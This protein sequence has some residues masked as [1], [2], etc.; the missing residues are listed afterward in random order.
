MGHATLWSHQTVLAAEPTSVS[1][2]RGFVE[3][4]LLEHDLLF[5]LEDIRL[6]ASELATIAISN[7]VGSFTLTLLGVEES[8]FLTVRHGLP[9]AVLQRSTR[10]RRE[11]SVMEA[12]SRG[13]AIVRLVCRDCGVN[14]DADGVESVWASFDAPKGRK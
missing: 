2:A 3:V 1:Q 13:F 6:A 12:Q 14:V 11:A 8:V 10:S 4:H 9:P 5:M 7:A